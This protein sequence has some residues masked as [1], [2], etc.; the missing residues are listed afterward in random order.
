MKLIVVRHAQPNDETETGGHGDPPLS[1][2]G[3]RQAAA[4]CEFLAGEHID[5]IVSS[6][7]VR[8]HQTALPL[9]EHLGMT[10]ELDDDLKEAGWQA[11]AYRRS[12][13]NED[14]YVDKIKSDPEFLYRPEGKAVFEE[15]ALGS[16]TRIRDENASKTVAVFCHGM[17]KNSL[18]A[19][20][21]AFEPRPQDF[22]PHYAA[23]TRFQASGKSNLW[24]LESFNETSHLRGL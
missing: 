5:H 3:L 18:I 13:E 21:I 23:I 1:E 6:P 17:V 20:A 11:G 7:M 24:T 8:A 15:R 16:F 2:L 10:P 12:E 14:F 19:H 22:H 9:C 4:V